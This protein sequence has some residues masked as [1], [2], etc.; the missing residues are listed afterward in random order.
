VK[1]QTAR[2]NNMK[3]PSQDFALAEKTGWLETATFWWISARPVVS[4]PRATV[5]KTND[6]NASRQSAPGADLNRNSPPTD[7]QIFEGN[8]PSL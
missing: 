2:P 7:C 8:F 4:S 6:I 1:E 5:K 3:K